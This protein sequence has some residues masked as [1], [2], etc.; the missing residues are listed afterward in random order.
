RAYVD[1][2][3]LAAVLELEERRLAEVAQ[4]DDAAGDGDVGRVG[5]PGV[6][7]GPE[8]RLHL[9]RAVVR[10]EVVRYGI[11]A[12]RAERRQ[13]PPPYHDLLVVL[14]HASRRFEVVGFY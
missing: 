6:V 9:A 14:R 4:R 7:D 8:A 10:T 2:Q 12:T 11:A 1:L 13:V 3:P 5:E